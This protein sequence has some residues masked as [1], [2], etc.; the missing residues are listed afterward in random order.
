MPLYIADYLADTGHLTTEEHGA[1]LLLIMH[2]WRQGELPN[3]DAQLAR[4]SRLSN[5]K[6]LSSRATLAGLFSEGWHHKRIAAELERTDKVSKTY[7][8]RAKKAAD[9]RWSK[10]AP[11]NASSMLEHAEPQSHKKDTEANASGA[12]APQ[13][14]TELLWAQGTEALL[15]MGS[16]QREARSNIGRWLKEHPPDAILGAIFRA[17]D[18]GSRD[19][20]PLVGRILKP[21]NRGKPNA[22]VGE[23]VHDAIRDI[24]R[25]VHE[26]ERDREAGGPSNLLAIGRF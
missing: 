1:Y 19:P 3:D 20:I 9:K 22:Q 15:A 10:D 12:D 14:P 7:A 6:W 24:Q 8:S 23:S 2:Y 4:I 17:R 11:N 26:Q 25:R 21:L 5:K 16:P 13:D 18:H